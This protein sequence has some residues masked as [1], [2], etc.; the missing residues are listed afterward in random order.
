[1]AVK[2]KSNSLSSIVFQSFSL[3]GS[4][5]SNSEY[6]IIPVIAAINLWTCRVYSTPK[7][8]A[9]TFPLLFHTEKEVKDVND[10]VWSNKPRDG[11]FQKYA[12]PY[13]V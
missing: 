5:G 2:S 9:H 10:G 12:W 13:K 8:I 3:T 1:M 11:V 7:K 4:I 6:F